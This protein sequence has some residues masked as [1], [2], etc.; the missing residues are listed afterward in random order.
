MT[1]DYQYV[2]DLGLIKSI[3]GK[4]QPANPIYGEVIARTLS[5][6][7]QE[8]FFLKK[9][10]ATI[11]RYLKEGKI[12]MTTLMLDFQQF[13]RENSDIWIE[14]FQYKEAA[15]HLILMAFLQRIINGGGYIIREMGAGTG[16]T[17]LCLVYN[18]Q[19][20]PIELKIRRG[21]KS[22]IEGIEQTMRYMDTF[23]CNEGWLAVFDRRPKT[24]WGKKIYVKKETVDGKTV[25]IVGL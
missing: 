24:A 13:W 11:S 20:Y 16:R 12:D 19:K 5:Y 25:T 8:K 7:A 4:I 18:N 10:D 2:T 22:I 6:D 23:G 14:K 9:P 1:D 17:D 15:P 3:G 21:E